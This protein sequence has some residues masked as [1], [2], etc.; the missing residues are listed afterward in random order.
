MHPESRWILLYSVSSKSNQSESIPLL[1]IVGQVC[2]DADSMS[3]SSIAAGMAQAM[4]DTL[5]TADYIGITGSIHFD[6]NHAT[7]QCISRAVIV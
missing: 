5:C 6:M 3:L 4:V 1:H 2:A 7:S